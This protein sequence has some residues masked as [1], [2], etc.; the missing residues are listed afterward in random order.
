MLTDKGLRDL[1]SLHAILDELERLMQA[2]SRAKALIK[3]NLASDL[4]QRSIS[5]SI[6]TSF[7]SSSLGRRRSRALSKSRVHD[8]RPIMIRP[9]VY[10]V[11]STIFTINF[12]TPQLSKVGYP[13][14]GTFSIKT[15]T[16]SNVMS[17][18]YSQV[19]FTTSQSFSQIHT[20]DCFS[21]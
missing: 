3:P 6:F 15:S 18:S 9:S 4:W 21:S 20:Y 11:L 16:L 8:T 17:R 5:L 12:R 13:K 10:G 7:I 1:F 2:E 19:C 14:G